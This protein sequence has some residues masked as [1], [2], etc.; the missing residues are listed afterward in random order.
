MRIGFFTNNYLP[1]H[2]GVAHSLENFR[3]ALE[4]LGNDVFIFAPRYSKKDEEN[5]KLFRYKSI[6]LHRNLG[7]LRAI[8]FP[9]SSKI[10][11]KIKDLNLDIIHSH[12]P[13]ILG[14]TAL[15]YAK[16]LNL[17][18]VFTVHTPYYQYIESMLGGIGELISPLILESNIA[19]ANR[20]NLAIVPTKTLKEKLKKAGLKSKIAVLPSG[21]QLE[22]FNQIKKE[23]ARKKLQLNLSDNIFLT[24][25]RLTYE[26]NTDFIIES[27]SI[28]AQALKRAKLIIVGNG[29]DK[30]RLVRLATSLNLKQNILFTGGIPYN[31]LPLYYS[32][33]DIFLYASII[34]TQGLVLCEAMASGLPIIATSQAIGT[35]D[36]VKNNQVGFLVK[37]KTNLFGRKA[38]ELAKSKTKLAE[39]S[40]NALREAKK[41]DHL[42]LARKLENIYLS[43]V[44]P[45]K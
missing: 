18:I 32:A 11:K 23:V 45:K 40:R 7:F 4:S 5:K 30:A 36:L 24:V 3:L 35:R 44:S 38:I 9:H 27:F 37:P 25:G 13:Y 15:K 19:Y 26:K 1:R 17:P 21:I 34:D 29:F 8:P 43:L 16:D 42:A 20:C 28:I 14:K 2:T 12:H 10:R 41:Y 6:R 22:K 33:A 39:F 31:K